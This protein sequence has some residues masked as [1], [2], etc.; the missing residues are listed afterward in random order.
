MRKRI[1]ADVKRAVCAA[2]D[3]DLTR[4][5][6]LIGRGVPSGAVSRFVVDLKNADHPLVRLMDEGQPMTFPAGGGGERSRPVTPLGALPYLAVPLHGRVGDEEV[7]AGVLLLTPISPT[8]V[9]EATWLARVLGHRLVRPRFYGRLVRERSLFP[10]RPAPPP[11]ACTTPRLAAARAS[12]C[13]RSTITRSRSP[14]CGAVS[15]SPSRAV[16]PAAR[17]ASSDTPA[18]LDQI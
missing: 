10:R 9:R 13:D 6:G 5:I 8:I 12:R 11:S 16:Y 3:P 18:P 1:A 7:P 14:R 2:V 4:L 15:R 17:A